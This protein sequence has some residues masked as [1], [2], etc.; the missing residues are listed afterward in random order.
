M[1]EKANPIQGGQHPLGGVSFLFWGLDF[2]RKPYF[3]RLIMFVLTY[4][5]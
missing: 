3:I 1:H 5:R 2:Y 4:I